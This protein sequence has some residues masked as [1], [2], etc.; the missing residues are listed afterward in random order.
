MDINARQIERITDELYKSKETDNGIF[1]IDISND[2]FFY[3]F[4]VLRDALSNF[5]ECNIEKI[6][7]E[8]LWEMNDWAKNI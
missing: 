4:D 8:L 2:K 6:S 7:K 1:V 3:I 5:D